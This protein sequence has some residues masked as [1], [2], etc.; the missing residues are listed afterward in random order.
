MQ[1]CYRLLLHIDNQID[2]LT[3]TIANSPREMSCTLY[4]QSRT[5][6]CSISIERKVAVGN[7]KFGKSVLNTLLP[8][9]KLDLIVFTM[10]TKICNSVNSVNRSRTTSQNINHQFQEKQS[11]TVWN[12]ID[13]SDRMIPYGYFVDLSIMADKKSCNG[14]IKVIVNQEKLI[15]MRQNFVLI[16]QQQRLCAAQWISNGGDTA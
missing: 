16:V 12:Y 11:C 6:N 5:N 8:D 2:I 10:F 1:Q 14:L 9:N 4:C 7:R 13:S 3:D 15:L